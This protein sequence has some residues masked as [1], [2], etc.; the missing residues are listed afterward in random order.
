MESVMEKTVFAPARAVLRL[1][2]SEASAE[3]TST[4]CFLRFWALGEEAS[5][6]MARR[7]YLKYF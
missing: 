5:R 1:S 6:V 3:T 4:P 2:M 7:V